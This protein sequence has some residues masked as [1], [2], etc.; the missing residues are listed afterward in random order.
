MGRMTSDFDEQAFLVELGQKVRNLRALRGMSRKTLAGVSGLSERY[1][2]Q[3]ESGQGNVSILLMLRLTRAM[4]VRL[5]DALPNSQDHADWLLIRDLLQRAT[6]SQVAATTR[7]LS[8][9]SES[10]AAAPRVAL[11]GLR[12]S[13]KSTLGRMVADQLGWQFSRAQ[14]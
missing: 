2:A 5:D 13:G 11:I 4:G 3:M 9:A 12:G 1:I 8:G 6:P 10:T 7:L 14:P